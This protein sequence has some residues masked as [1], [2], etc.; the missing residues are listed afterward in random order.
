MMALTLT[1][2]RVR[3][4]ICSTMAARMFDTPTTLLRCC[5]PCL[6]RTAF[7]LALCYNLGF[8]VPADHEKAMDSLAASGRN[9][10][11]LRDE[12]LRVKQL[13]GL[14]FADL[15]SRSANLVDDGIIAVWD[16]VDDYRRKGLMLNEVQ[17]YHIRE[18]TDMESVLGDDSDL[19]RMLKA[20]LARVY[21]LGGDFKHVERLRRELLQSSIGKFG[22][23]GLETLHA[24]ENLGI[25]LL[26]TGE[27]AEAEGLLHSAF[28]G[29]SSILGKSHLATLA[30]Q[31]QWC[32]TLNMRGRYA[33]AMPIYRGIYHEITALLGVMHP[34][35]LTAMGNWASALGAIGD[36]K[37]SKTLHACV[38]TDREII[39]GPRHEE[40]LNSKAAVASALRR[41][42]S[43]PEAEKMHQSAL[44]GFNGVVGASRA[45]TL[46]ALEEFA[47]TLEIQYRFQ[48]A[49]VLR[50]RAR[51]LVLEKEKALQVS[52]KVF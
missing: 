9:E 15:Q 44:D 39:L 5:E 24:K 16:F 28:A 29:M 37:F 25:V 46:I 7:Q 35:S 38:L 27:L 2:Y 12:V 30:A 18:F 3:Q 50:R 52:S 10:S 42:G 47:L 19:V 11:D 49:E 8:G 40:T 21:A 41:L 23:Q 17:D 22:D 34:E 33:E 4:E 1:D 26:G 51:G 32:E 48:E 45:N 6:R 36:F 13:S 31:T 20:V 14:G 43:Y